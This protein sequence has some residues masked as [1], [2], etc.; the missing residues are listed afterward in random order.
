ML[1]FCVYGE[2]RRV[3]FTD[4]YKKTDSELAKAYYDCALKLFEALFDEAIHGGSASKRNK[5]I[6]AC[7]RF[8]DIFDTVKEFYQ[9]NHN[10]FYIKDRFTIKSRSS[11]SHS[12]L[13]TS[14]IYE[15]SKKAAFKDGINYNAPDEKGLYF[16]GNTVFNPITH[17]EFYWV[18]VGMTAQTLQKR[19]RQY[20]TSNPMMWRIDYKENA[21]D[22]ESYYHARLNS[23]CIATNGHSDEWF[24]VN[25]ETYFEMCNKGFHY[26]D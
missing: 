16:I 15:Q 6:N 10:A 25:R 5:Y 23:V 9:Y 14:D 20:N 21:E 19:L 3:C 8:Y 1:T 18:K 13:S 17:Q 4:I 11:K 24:L 7:Y 22:E 12:S 2:E 26:F